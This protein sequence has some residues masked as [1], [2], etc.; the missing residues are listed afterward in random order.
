MM[1]RIR[2]GLWG[3][4][5]MLAGA[6]YAAP[7]TPAPAAMPA[8]GT[9]TAAVAALVTKASASAAAAVKPVD[10]NTVGGVIQAGGWC[11]IALIGL[12]VIGVALAVYYL[13]VLRP[14]V[15]YP[16]PFLRQLEVAAA[17]GNLQEMR[18][19]CLASDAPA[20]QV[21]LGGLEQLDLDSAADYNTVNAA[22]E[23]EGSRQASS[24][25]QKIQY[26]LDVAVVAPMVGL[27]GTVLGMLQ[28]F[29]GIQAEIGSVIPTALAHGVAMALIT[30]AGGLAVGIPAMIAYAVFRGRVMSLVA[31]METAC[32]RIMRRLCFSLKTG[33]KA[34]PKGK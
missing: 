18:D 29:A 10:F 27:L 4:G 8:T 32:G 19:L 34:P 26:L 24:L 11:M 2:N 5:L 14:A 30:T 21:I 20:A 33:A 25:W 31:G 23:D 1:N 12:S 13:L 17:N 6:L 22:M 7:A 28:S 9:S 3:A 15:L 16:E